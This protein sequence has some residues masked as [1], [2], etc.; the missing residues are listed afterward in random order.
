MQLIKVYQVLLLE[1][2]ESSAKLLLHTLERY[3]FN[4]THVSD[5]QAGLSKLRSHHF[6]LIISDVM[7][8]YLDGISFLQKAK[9]QVAG[10]PVIMLTSVGE[11]ESVVRAANQNISAYLLKPIA[12]QT[13]LEKIAQLL[14]LKPEMIVDKKQHP[15]EVKI[16]ETSI[17]QM[18][19]EISGCP[20]KKAAEEIYSKF[21][22]TLAGRASFSN[23]RIHLKSDF[24]LEVSALKIL[25]DLVAKITKHSQ[26]RSH[27]LSLDSDFF[28]ETVS[29]LTPFPFLSEV[30]II[31]K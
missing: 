23:L 21:A 22:H 28:R 19:M 16:S 3:N 27:S 5:G 2:D 6:D 14:S 24:F 25:D 7:M 11:K 1:D 4:V 10:T 17:S 20:G 26:I 12:T 9:E 8:P 18:L 30:N 29:D 13:L 31:S 15:L